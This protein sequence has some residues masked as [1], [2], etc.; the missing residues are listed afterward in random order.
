M[1]NILVGTAD[2]SVAAFYDN[3]KRLETTDGG[4]LVYGTVGAGQTAL[5]V[6]GDIKATGVVTAVS[7]TVRLQVLQQQLTQQDFM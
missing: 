1:V 6:E 7:L 4:A 3:T 2:G 5:V